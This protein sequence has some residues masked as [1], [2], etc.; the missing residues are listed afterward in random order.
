M[1]EMF[2]TYERQYQELVSGLKQGCVAAG[3]LNEDQRRPK[4]LELKTALDEG[5][6]LIRR[7]DLE[8]RGLQP[9]QKTAFLGKL[10]NYKA[11]L[12]NLKREVKM[13][14]MGAGAREQL[15]E[16]GQFTTSQ[17]QQVQLAAAT[18]RMYQ[19][20]DRI[21]EGKKVL[22]ETEELGVSI[23]QDLHRQREVLQHSKNTLHGVDDNIARGKVIIHN[24]SRRI[25]RNKY[26][27]AGLIIFLLLAILVI[28]TGKR[29]HS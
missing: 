12:T 19:T 6:S 28:A 25:T 22:V 14:S 4:V 11:E 17:E 5:D 23:L 15:L 1:S 2:Q 13:M 27:M 24:I 20:G 16:S 7:M 10:K 29:P 21:R 8:A 9:P 3:A 26:I 18:D